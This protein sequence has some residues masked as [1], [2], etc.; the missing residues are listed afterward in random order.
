MELLDKYLELQKEIYEY[1][2][3]KEDWRVF[4][5]EDCRNYYWWCDE[6]FVRFAETEEKLQDTERG[7]YYENEV[8]TYRHLDK[9]VYKGDDYTMIICDT[10]TDGNIFISI[11]SNDRERQEADLEKV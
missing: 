6:R 10:H 8:Y 3:Y 2:G 1:F 7:E 11:F 5:I 9:Y 4:P